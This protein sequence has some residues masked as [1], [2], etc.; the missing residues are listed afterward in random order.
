L[1]W[2]ERCKKYLNQPRS[3]GICFS[4]GRKPA[5]KWENNRPRSGG[6]VVTQ[7]LQPAGTLL[8]DFVSSL[9]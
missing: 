4:R 9:S 1:R 3:G 8:S 6:S 5:V 7:S 2:D